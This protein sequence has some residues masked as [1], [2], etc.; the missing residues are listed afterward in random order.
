MAIPMG[1]T[2]RLAEYAQGFTGAPNLPPDVAERAKDMMVNAAAVALAAAA[3]PDS[4]ALTRFAQDMQGNGR[5]T[6]IGMGLRS[7]PI[8]AALVNGAMV[9]LLDFDDEIAARGI[10]PSGAV[11][12]AVMALG[13]MNGSPGADVL[14]AY[15]LGCEV[16]A[17]LEGCGDGDS[18]AMPPTSGQT[19][20]A[21]GVAGAVGAAIA[22]A[23]VLRLNAGQTE[24]AL[25][26]ACGAAGVAGG[27]VSGARAL[28][29]GQ[30]A[31]TGVMAGLL[32]QRG[33]SAEPGAMEAP[34]GWLDAHRRG[35][36]FDA[37][38]FFQKLGDPFD[39]IHPGVTLKFYPCA[40]ASHTTVEALLQLQQQYQIEAGQVASVQVGVTA[41]ALKSL[42][43][44]TPGNGREAK[45]CLSYIAAAT[46]LHGHPLIDHFSDLAVEDSEVRQAMDRVTVEATESATRLIPNPS[47]VAMTLVDGRQLRHRVEYARG[48][49]QLPLDRQELDAKF[50]YCSRY[51]LP[52]DHIE[53][54]IDSF[55]DLENIANVTGMAS[56]L[57]G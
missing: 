17:K 43:F 47:S 46:L 34:G 24:N 25:G 28:Q 16:I 52:A 37:D 19:A 1:F 41:D 11:F 21:V 55:R 44:P 13:E 42:P 38:S 5:C 9:H 30:A 27:G 26:I 10:H 48:Y 40:S 39:I 23:S 20:A 45:S 56:V 4:R 14:A 33:I 6:I 18:W 29:R 7:S 51:I 50:L 12:P 49:P 22:A 8:Y 3:Q 57:G 31:M 54:A 15:V 53:E 32:A 36:N 2:R 35:S